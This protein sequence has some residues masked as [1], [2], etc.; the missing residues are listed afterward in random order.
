M[1]KCWPVHANSSGNDIPVLRSDSDA[2]YRARA[3]HWRR[4]EGRAYLAMSKAEQQQ[5]RSAA[6]RD[7]RAAYRC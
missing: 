4:H 7:G 5:V 2:S 6:H 1:R 3:A